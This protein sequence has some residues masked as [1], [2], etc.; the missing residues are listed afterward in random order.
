MMP[1]M[2]EYAGFIRR[3]MAFIVDILWI[4]PLIVLLLYLYYGSDYVQI[5]NSIYMA[6]QLEYFDW[7]VFLINHILPALLIIW[8]WIKYAATPGKLLLD[9]EIVDAITGQPITFKQALLRYAAYIV[10]AL[11]LGLGFFWILWDKQK[12]AWHDKIANTVVIIHDEATVSL[13]Q[14][15]INSL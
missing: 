14:L 12:Q 15:Y 10:S 13:H 7:R 9:C 5:Q 11:P 6:S 4:S 3:L 8:F 2:T 1:F